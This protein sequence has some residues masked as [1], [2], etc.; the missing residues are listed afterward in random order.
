MRRTLT[1]T[2]SRLR[3]ARANM[4]WGPGTRDGSPNGLFALARGAGE[5]RGEGLVPP[6][7]FYF[8]NPFSHLS[9]SFLFLAMVFSGPTKRMK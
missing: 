1:L 2:L 7:M 5:G 9:K 6:Q 3:R 4:Q 8:L